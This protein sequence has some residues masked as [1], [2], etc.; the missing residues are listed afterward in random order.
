MRDGP[1]TRAPLFK[2]LVTGFVALSIT[3]SAHVV[4]VLGSA[5]ASHSCAPPAVS[6]GSGDGQATPYVI[7]S[8]AE[9]ELLR[10][11]STYWDDSFTL[12]ANLSLSHCTWSSGIGDS[13]TKFTG[14]F[15]GN[16]RAITDLTVSVSG[17]FSSRPND[18]VAGLFGWVGTGG[19]VR[20]LAVTGSVEARVDGSQVFAGGVVGRALEADL[21]NVSFEGSVIASGLTDNPGINDHPNAGGVLGHGLDV[22]LAGASADVSVEAVGY[23]RPSAGGLVGN[24]DRTFPFGTAHIVD[25]WAVGTVLSDG[26]DQSSAGGLV[27][28]SG[29]VRISNS[30]ALVDVTAG[31]ATEPA[32]GGVVGYGR[33]DLENTFAQGDVKSP[34][35]VGGLV[36]WAIQEDSGVD[37]IENSYFTG[38]LDDSGTASLSVGGIAGHV[39]TQVNDAFQ[40]PNSFWDTGT[41]GIPVAAGTG[42]YIFDPTLVPSPVPVDGAQGATGDQMRSLG[43]Y[44]A[45]GWVIAEG[46]SPSSTWSICSGYNDGYPYL[47]SLVSTDPCPGPK[48]DPGPRPPVRPSAPDSPVARAGDGTADVSWTP[49]L[50]QGLSPIQAYEVAPSPEG[51]GCLVDGAQTLCRIS[52]LQNGT[53]YQFFVRAG[54]SFGWGPWSLPSNLVTP[55]ALP[56]LMRSITIQGSRDVLSPRGRTVRIEGQTQGL[57]GQKLTPHLR[58]GATGGFRPG[59]RAAEVQPDGTFVWT[60]QTR[61]AVSAYFAIEDLTSNVIEVPAGVPRPR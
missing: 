55:M 48:P 54:N 4:S 6:F 18:G 44:G 45:V 58:L 20:D 31:D 39:N 22:R 59:V 53:V 9:L 5:K 16:D 12:G 23:W 36:G 34:R 49:P 47:S 26:L 33:A 57:V 32:A 19:Y 13:V 42:E 51:P 50:R 56:P 21:L 3:A 7:D 14:V 28:A 60:R 2:A 41:T 37:V 46:Y 52:G 24:L 15:D 25:S 29:D 38:V 40:A 27:G 30:Y 1:L 35:F 11:D 8:N 61:K 10:D 43:T 17:D